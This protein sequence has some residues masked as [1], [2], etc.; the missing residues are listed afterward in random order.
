V[1]ELGDVLSKQ[2]EVLSLTPTYLADVLEDIRRVGAATGTHA[3]AGE[4]VAQLQARMDAVA[5]KTAAVPHRPRV[6]QLEWVEP[7]LCG[8][9]WV[10]E[11]VEVAG[12]A[13]CFGSRDS[14]ASR[15]DWD[16]VV[17]SQPEMVLF[18]PCGFGL[19]RAL[20][21]LP[22]LTAQPGWE[23]LPAVRN[24]QV[25]VM[26]GGAYTSRLGPRLATGLEI[27]A[28]LMHPNLFSGMIPDGAVRRIP[29][30]T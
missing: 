25:Y 14:G 26:D 2:P 4:L 20:E 12:G 8:G 30:N 5:E 23:D 18:M 24:G 6:L 11:M 13:P 16:D 21:D 1:A 29:P 22:I 28:E 19:E 3:R 10:V 9:H 7:L 27:L 17:A 15:L